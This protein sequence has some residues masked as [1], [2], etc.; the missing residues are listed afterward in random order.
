MKL[1]VFGNYFGYENGRSRTRVPWAIQLDGPQEMNMGGPYRLDVD[2]LLQM[3]VVGRNR[4]KVD[5]PWVSGR[6]K[7]TVQMNW[8][9]TVQNDITWTDRE[10]KANVFFGLDSDC[11]TSF[12]GNVHFIPWAWRE[13]FFI[14]FISENPHFEWSQRIRLHKIPNFPEF[15]A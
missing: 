13:R 4:R 3:K 11:P 7:Y 5:V 15:P 10:D 2:G 9:W 1:K 8:L 12:A 14:E 6:W